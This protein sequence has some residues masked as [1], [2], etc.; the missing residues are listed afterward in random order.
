[1]EGGRSGTRR[2]TQVTLGAKMIRGTP[3]CFGVPRLISVRI[4]EYSRQSPTASGTTSATGGT[5]STGDS[6]ATAG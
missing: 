4:F 3:E 5:T 2:H 6:S 1:M